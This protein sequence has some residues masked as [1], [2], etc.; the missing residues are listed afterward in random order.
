I[1]AAAL[2]LLDDSDPEVSYAAAPLAALSRGREAAPALLKFLAD[3]DVRRT[4]L[5]T[6][7]LPQVS[8][9]DALLP[10]LQAIRSRDPLT[11]IAAAWS[12]GLT[13]DARAV[14]PLIAALEAGTADND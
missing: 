3:P 2:A 11:R 4:R 8:P 14:P 6:A 10:L 9:E 1:V 13:K 5:M 7:L 12:L